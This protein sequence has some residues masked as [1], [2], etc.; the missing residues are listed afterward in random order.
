M[1]IDHFYFSDE[2]VSNLSESKTN[3]FLLVF[4]MGK[5]IY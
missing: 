1:T 3:L 5:N 2:I 4:K